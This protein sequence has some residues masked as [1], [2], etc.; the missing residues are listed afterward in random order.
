[1]LKQEKEKVVLELTEKMKSAKAIYLTDFTGLDVIR[2]TELRKKLREASVE[3]QVVKNT[4]AQLAAKNAGME[5]LM[6]YLTGPTGLAF[7]I[8]DPIVPA[9]ILVEFGK[10]DNKPS[11]KVGVV[12]GKMVDVQQ[13]KQLA[14][15][16]SREVLLSQVLSALQ[17]PISGLVGALEGIIRKFVGTVDAIAKQKETN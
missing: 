2:A 12:E 9:K 1:M 6:D 10:D 13:V 16:P 4:L 5:M 3:Y 14:M 11:V 7:G 15:L 17:S 8:K